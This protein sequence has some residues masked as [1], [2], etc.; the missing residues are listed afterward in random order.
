ME[1]IKIVKTSLKKKKQTK[2]KKVKKVKKIK[3]NEEIKEKL[4]SIV[5]K[6]PLEQEDF[7]NKLSKKEGRTKK[8]LRDTLKSLENE[9]KGKAISED[10][11]ESSDLR[12]NYVVMSRRGQIE[13]FWNEQP[14]YYDQS[15]IFWLWDKEKYQW[16]ISDEI[17]FCNSIFELLHIDTI[18][19]KT[20]GEIIEGFKQVGRKHKPKDIKKSWVQYKNKIYDVQTKESFKASPEYFVKN[21]IPWKVGESEE[22]PTIDKYFD[23][24]I[25]GQDKSWKESLYEIIAYN[26]STDKFMQRI[27]GCIGGGSNGKGTFIKLNYKFLGEENC[28]SSEIKSL[29]EDRFEPAVLYGKLLC[30]MG[31]VSHDDLKNTNQLKKLGGEDKISFQFKNKTPFT[32]ENTS[33]CICLT[34]SMPITPDRTIGFYRKWFLLDFLNQFKVLDKNLI[35]CIPDIEFENLAKKSLRILKKLYDNPHF[36]NEGD[37]EERAKRYEERSNPVMKFVEE[38]C[39]ELDGEIITLRN[40]TNAC[41]IYLKSK[42]LRIMNSN[43]I[44]KILRDE[45]FVVGSRK[46]KDVSA[47]VILNLKLKN[48][49]LPPKPLLPPKSLITSYKA[50]SV[51]M[52]GNSGSSGFT[53]KKTDIFNEIPSNEGKLKEVLEDFEK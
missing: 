51:K 16:V 24:W 38:N 52:G 27:I 15:K 47:R 5:G 10:I 11:N 39:E 33:T 48:T 22:T 19:S 40:F 36:T 13:E 18:E 6:E 23:D 21:P 2:K 43:Q 41:N 50:S 7:I 14:F 30:V 1:E 3:T 31:E 49:E 9:I 29:S 34:N 35:D 32:E 42:H 46:I 20:K 4:K 17:D 12:K 25:K 26:T 53:H 44:G 8:V 45:G 28:V 37:F